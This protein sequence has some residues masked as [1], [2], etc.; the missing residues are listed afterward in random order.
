MVEKLE[1]VATFKG[2][3][4]REPREEYI[5]RFYDV[6]TKKMRRGGFDYKAHNDFS[7]GGVLTL[8]ALEA[9][10]MV[11]SLYE[12]DKK[13]HP[14]GCGELLAV[15]YFSVDPEKQKTKINIC[16]E[17][18]ELFLFNSFDPYSA[19]LPKNYRCFRGGVLIEDPLADI[20]LFYNPN[21]R[22]VKAVRTA[23]QYDGYKTSRKK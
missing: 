20:V 7:P 5:Q 18:N 17:K 16:H 23:R 14:R 22:I 12:R 4:K 10:G 11:G 19:P 13:G 15:S 1:V 6:V 2:V 21:L 9:A 3:T 8:V